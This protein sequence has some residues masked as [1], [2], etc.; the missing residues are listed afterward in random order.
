M[1]CP[2]TRDRAAAVAAARTRR[3]LRPAAAAA[4]TRRAQS[5]ASAP[6]TVSLTVRAE[7]LLVREQRL[8]RNLRRLLQP[9]Q[10]HV[11]RRGAE[12]GAERRRH[13]HAVARLEPV[14]P[15]E[16]LVDAVDEHARRPAA[17][18]ASWVTNPRVA[19][20]GAA[21]GAVARPDP[22]R[23]PPGRSPIDETT[24]PVR[25]SRDSTRS[26]RLPRTESPT[27]SAPPSTDTAAATPRPTARLV[28]QW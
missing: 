27:S 7:I 12:L 22:P 17:P 20:S 14:E 24:W 25:P 1:T 26:R 9:R 19:I 8:E 6:V 2:P 15:P 13:E 11:A 3:A 5:A 10:Q 28:R 16:P 18:T 4:R 23:A 21:A